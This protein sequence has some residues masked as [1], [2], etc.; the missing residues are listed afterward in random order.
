ME[1]RIKKA[2]IAGNS[3]AVILPRAW[4][5][6]EVRVELVKKTP[7]TILLDTINILKEHISL[8]D[9]IGIYLTGSYARKEEDKGSDIDILVITDNIDKELIKHGIYNILLVSSKLLKQKIK[10]DLFP[11][12][13]MIKE[14]EPLLN[15]NYLSSIEIKVTKENIKWYIE[16]T[17]DKLNIINQAIKSKNKIYLSD[18]LAYTLILRIRTLYII[19]KLAENKNYSKQE[20]LKLIKKVS[21]GNN[22]YERYLVIKNNLEDEHKL[23]IKEA[24]KLY[25]YLKNQLDNTKKLV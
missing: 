13:Q 8:K 15:S 22:A 19:K 20:F 11:I 6:Q 14:A 2:V 23:G 4:L 17:E 12:G 21:G 16:T 3:S 5:N 7:E 18:K 1:V 9:V 10:Q 24:E 25:I